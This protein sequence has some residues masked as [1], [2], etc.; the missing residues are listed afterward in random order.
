MTQIFRLLT[1]G[2]FLGKAALLSVFTVLASF[3]GMMLAKR[4]ASWSQSEGVEKYID[5]AAE[6]AGLAFLVLLLAMT[7]LRFRPS[8]TATG[9]EPRV[10]AILGTFLTLSLVALPAVDLGSVWRVTC[11][12]IIATGTALSV[13]VLAWLGRSFSIMAQARRLVTNGPYAIVRHPLYVCEEIAVVG[14]VLLH[15]SPL[16]LLIVVVQWMF[17]LR[18]MSNEEH[19]LRACF[20]EYATYAART[21]KII[22]RLFGGRS[23][24]L[25]ES[26]AKPA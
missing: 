22:P 26:V 18:R 3:K 12:V 9:W 13:W 19:V 15:L 21:P 25:A 7:L 4:L 14:L 11:I 10:S 17:Q 6:I 8:K 23:S 24:V 20:P 5:V 16:A 1:N 2:E